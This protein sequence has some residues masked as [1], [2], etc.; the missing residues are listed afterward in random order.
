MQISKKVV[1]ILNKALADELA[2]INQ[3]MVHSEMCSN[4]GYEFLHKEIE[5]RA[6]TEMKHAEKLIERI[7][8]LE[9]EPIVTNLSKINIGKNV[10]EI[11][12]Y[13]L[14][15]ELGAVKDYNE[16][17]K[18]CAEEKDNVSK[19]LFEELLKDEESHVDWIENQIEQIKQMGLQVYLLKATKE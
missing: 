10:Q 14:K 16:Y 2:A 8:F 1:E 12:E 15:A 19:I 5:K 17:V 7:L 6:F 3:Y 18:V 13:D 11:M 9:G 4:W